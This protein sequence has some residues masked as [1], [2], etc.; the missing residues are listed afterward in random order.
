MHPPSPAIGRP[1]FRVRSGYVARTAPSCAVPA[2]EPGPAVRH[3]PRVAGTPPLPHQ[4]DAWDGR[5]DP[6][7]SSGGASP[8]DPHPSRRGD[9]PTSH[10]PAH[11]TRH[12]SGPGTSASRSR[13]PGRAGAVRGDGA[14]AFGQWSR[15]GTPIRHCR[16]RDI[17]GY[18]GKVTGRVVR[19]PAVSRSCH[20][21]T[22]FRIFRYRFRTARVPCGSVRG[23]ARGKQSGDDDRSRGADHADSRRLRLATV[24][25]FLTVGYRRNTPRRDAGR[26]F[27]AD[28]GRRAPLRV[29][30]PNPRQYASL[31]PPSGAP[32]LASTSASRTASTSGSQGAADPGPGTRSQ[33]ARPVPA[34]D[35]GRRR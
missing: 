10:A 15:A 28:P 20:W 25:E 30:R 2:A 6:K 7:R 33:C 9:A 23:S 35:G 14:F 22:G 18:A 5:F 4:S 24:R 8:P 1:H 21:G 12:M 17:G 31:L 16:R 13:T 3:R 32:V 29:G 27:T 11:V 34:S 26:P 19:K